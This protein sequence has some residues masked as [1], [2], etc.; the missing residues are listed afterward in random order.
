MRNS[1]W[2]PPPQSLNEIIDRLL[3]RPPIG[4]CPCNR[5][6]IKTAYGV[7]AMQ[8]PASCL[9]V[10]REEQEVGRETSET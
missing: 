1:R 5:M 9:Q 7:L 4:S 10:Q 8:Y 3:G 6:G 2:G